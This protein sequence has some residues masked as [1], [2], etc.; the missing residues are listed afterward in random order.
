MSGLGRD[1]DARASSSDDVPELFQ[2]HGSAV[3]IDFQDRFDRGLR[4]RYARGLDEPGD[5]AQRGG[6][7][8][9]GGNG[10][11]RRYVNAGGPDVEPSVNTE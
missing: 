6:G 5:L 11:L 3:Q 2:N 7:R 10:F 9:E 8:D 1:D 4:R